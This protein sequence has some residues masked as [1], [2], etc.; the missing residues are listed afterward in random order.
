MPDDTSDRVHVEPFIATDEERRVALRAFSE[1][2]SV[3]QGLGAVGVRWRRCKPGTP[4]FREL[5]A[6]YDKLLARQHELSD[7]IGFVL[8]GF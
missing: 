6:S 7:V 3:S 8:R 5:E 4:R 2:K 1:I